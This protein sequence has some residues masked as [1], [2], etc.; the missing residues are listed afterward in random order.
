MR[1]ISRRD[2][3]VFVAGTLACLGFQA[4]VWAP[5]EI[6]YS[7]DSI[8][9]IASLIA[10]SGLFLGI[11]IVL[12]SMRAL[13]WA[14]ILLWLGL[15]LDVI[16]VCVLVLGRF[17]MSPKVPHMSLYRSISSVLTLSVLLWML[18]WSQSKRFKD[19]PDA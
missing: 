9:V 14:Q 18:L 13:R 10:G 4:L 1:N 11:G 3:Q 17:G 19:E 16:S 7:R 15:L 6:L 8:L 5:Y 12:G 2:I